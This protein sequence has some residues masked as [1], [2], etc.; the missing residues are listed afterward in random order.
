MI[1]FVKNVMEMELKMDQNQQHVQ[2]V[3]EEEVEQYIIDKDHMLF[4]VNNH[5]QDVKEKEK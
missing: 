4:K 3:M 1:L 2:I 5:V